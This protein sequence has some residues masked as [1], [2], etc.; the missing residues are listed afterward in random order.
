M[1]NLGKSQSVQK[2]L[3][4][5]RYNPKIQFFFHKVVIQSVISKLCRIDEIEDFVTIRNMECLA[6]LRQGGRNM[7]VV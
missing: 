7:Y 4:G 1:P 5:S 2:V 6:T 3:N